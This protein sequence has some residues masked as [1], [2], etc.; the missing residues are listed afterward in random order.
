MHIFVGHSFGR[1][2]GGWPT[3]IS[4]ESRGIEE[5]SKLQRKSWLDMHSP[6]VVFVCSASPP[7][8]LENPFRCRNV[9]TSSLPVRRRS[10]AVGLQ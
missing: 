5:G 7:T 10:R 1:D 9:A 6:A 3:R 4:G 2:G 8:D